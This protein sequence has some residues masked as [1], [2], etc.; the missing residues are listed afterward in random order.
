MHNEVDLVER[1]ASVP[2][3]AAET[4]LQNYCPSS[5]RKW[6]RGGWGWENP[7]NSYS[8]LPPG[9]PGCNENPPPMYRLGKNT[10]VAEGAGGWGV[11]GYESDPAGG[12][13]RSALAA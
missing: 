5:Q 1:N 10:R 3:E 8:C 7:C 4:M 13:F 12:A 6:Q 11:R 2:L 9:T